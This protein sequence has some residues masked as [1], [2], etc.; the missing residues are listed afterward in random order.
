MHLG[1]VQN[2]TAGEEY[3]RGWHPE[4]FEPA[5]NRDRD[6]LV[7]GAGPAGLECA[8]V[9]GKRGFRRV[10][11][12][13]ADGEIGGHLRWLTRLPGVGEWGRIV[14]WRRVQLDRLGNVEVLTGVR[15]R[16][17]DVRGYGAELVVLAT[18]SS[19]AGDGLNGM[20]HEPIPGADA[21]HP[22]VLTPEQVMVD[23]KRPPG[24]RVCVY[25]A[26]G[27]QVAS[28]LAEALATEGFEVE[29][30]TPF[31][32]VAPE[33]DA[34]LE[35]PL[36]R[37]RLHDA[38]VTARRNVTVT[39]VRPDGL[40]AEGE[41]GEPL[42]L[43]IDG[44]V[45]VT[46]R[47]ADDALY[48]ALRSVWDEVRAEGVEGVFRIG[49]CLSPRH[50]ADAIWDGHRLGREID[51]DDPAVPLPVRRELPSPERAAAAI[52]GTRAQA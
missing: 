44:V 9:L 10:H 30:V 28:G 7:V 25:D 48:L 41:F 47:V 22:H 5:A 20:S 6:V 3:R 16:P 32:V 4:R 42:E 31:D 37:R 27:Y 45:L 26:E 40:L 38:G 8:I 18:G 35:G 14:N 49:D 34:S 51:S 15:L 46:Q 21:S 24:R 19:W 43:G 17:E 23:G 39:G 11:L 2:A 29:L 36:L 1:C 50:V 13:E 52:L 12:V 33:C